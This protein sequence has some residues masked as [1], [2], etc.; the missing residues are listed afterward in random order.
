MTSPEHERF[1]GAVAQKA[2]LSPEAAERAALATLGTLAERLS[3]GQARDLAEQL[4]TELAPWLMTR[5]GP[6][7]FDV[8]VFVRRVAERE[9]TDPSSATRHAQAVFAALGRW[10][11]EDEIADMAAE[12]P[13]D[14]EPF[15]AEAQRRFVEIVPAEEFRRRVARRAGIDEE[16][17]RR[18]TDAVLET[19]AERIAGGEVDDLIAQLPLELHEPLRRGDALSKGAARRMSLDEFVRRVA[20]REGVTPAE[21]REHARAVFATLRE[22]VGEHEFFDVVAQLPYGYAALE[23]RP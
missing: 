20:E 9:G 18:A 21:A 10:V 14:F 8:D 2:R 6:E 23:P 12:L 15:V 19:L 1:I 3:A 13:R 4:P 17:A 22:A 11:A 16:A 5:S 7:P